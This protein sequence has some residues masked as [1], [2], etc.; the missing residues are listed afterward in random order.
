MR[1]IWTKY[2]RVLSSE[3][4]RATT[5]FTLT[6]INLTRERFILPAAVPALNCKKYFF[7][8]G[9]FFPQNTKLDL[10]CIFVQQWSSYEHVMQSWQ[11]QSPRLTVPF[12]CYYSARKL[13][14]SVL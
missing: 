6:P 10:V 3:K 1:I 7:V 4:R 5:Y 2:L 12:S 9:E 14:R 13:W 8:Q 11:H